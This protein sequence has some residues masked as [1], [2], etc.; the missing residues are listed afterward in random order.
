MYIYIYTNIHIHIYNTHIYNTHYLSP[1]ILMLLPDLPTSSRS[2]SSR[3]GACATRPT[4]R[5]KS[6]LTRAKSCAYQT[7]WAATWRWTEPD[8]LRHASKKWQFQSGKCWSPSNLEVNHSQ[9]NPIG[10]MNIYLKKYKHVLKPWFYEDI[11]SK[12]G[13]AM[14]PL[15]HNKCRICK[16]I[17]SWNRLGFLLGKRMFWFQICYAV[18]FH[19]FS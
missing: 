18:C 12:N 16:P 19:L 3:R 7:L 9:T 13:K 17:T 10:G 1:N 11:G 14:K 2:S 4:A 5:A 6:K 8:D 15:N